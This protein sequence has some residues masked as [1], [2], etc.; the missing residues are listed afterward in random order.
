MGLRMHWTSTL[1]IVTGFEV[2]VFI[3]G[4]LLKAKGTYA[5]TLACVCACVCV[6]V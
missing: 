4:S 6:C 1:S 2:C 3:F 5:V